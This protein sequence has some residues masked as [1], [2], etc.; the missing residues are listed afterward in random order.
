MHLST[1]YRYVT[2]LVN[3]GFIV[4]RHQGTKV[5]LADVGTKAL[6]LALFLPIIEQMLR[7]T[8]SF[9]DKEYITHVTAFK[10]DVED[11]VA[12]RTNLHRQRRLD[13]SLD[14]ANDLRG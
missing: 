14:T 10:V 9:E 5:L 3:K 11:E 1:K 2:E 12:M 6:P 4:L 7:T 8:L 13:H